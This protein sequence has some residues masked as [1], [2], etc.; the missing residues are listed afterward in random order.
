MNFPASKDFP[1]NGPVPVQSS[2][3]IAIAKA[4][5]ETIKV[6]EFRQILIWPLALDMSTTPHTSLL[7]D[8]VKEE[9][10]RLDK[11]LGKPWTR[12]VDPLFHIQ[13]EA[14]ELKRAADHPPLTPRERQEAYAEF[15]YFHDFVQRFLYPTAKDQPAGDVPLYVFK[16]DDIGFVQASIFTG[17]NV[18]PFT[19]KIERC[20]LYMFPVGV[21]V[22]AFEV[23]TSDA[24][25]APLN[26][27]QVMYLQDTLRR[28]YTPYFEWLD[29]SGSYAARGTVSSM[30]WLDANRRPIGQPKSPRPFKTEIDHVVAN[31]EPP[32]FE[33]WRDLLSLQVKGQGPALQSSQAT[34]RHVVD[35]RIPFT[36]YIRLAAIGDGADALTAYQNLSR[37]YEGD[38]MRLCFADTPGDAGS[39]PYDQDFLKEFETDNCYNRFRN[40]GTRHMFCGYTYC[41][42]TAEGKGYEPF[43][44]HHFRHMYFQMALIAHMEMAAYLAFSSRVSQAVQRASGAN[45]LMEPEFRERIIAIQGEFL[46]FVQM[47]RFTGI[48]NQIQAKEMFD[49]WRQHLRLQTLYEDVRDELSAATNFLFAVEARQQTK[50]AL[51]Q[52][53]SALQLSEAATRLNK[54][55][56][57]GVVLSLVF[58]FL[59]INVIWDGE[60][61]KVL[62]GQAEI[63]ADGKPRSW[64]LAASIG[65][66]AAIFG[67]SL[68]AFTSLALVFVPGLFEG[69]VKRKLTFYMRV[70]RCLG[71]NHA[72]PDF[73]VLEIERFLRWMF[74]VGLSVAAVGVL[75]GWSGR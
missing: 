57:A 29:A 32:I 16:R 53:E 33:P 59:G 1:M 20:N 63:A 31:R 25:I 24:T 60:T 7:A 8:I 69:K 27:T 50:S 15:V 43:L 28:C 11:S 56:I 65:R 70:R 34:W 66:G 45:R 72:E 30:Q 41:M 37:V 35:E 10:V 9:A 51:Q 44:V 14:D 47:Y 23:S 13:R 61:M 42:L 67:T 18:E 21:A 19:L 12:I 2:A 68:L 40:L 64:S 74:V 54:I 58:G 38:L 5:P 62:L 46:S 17:R 49:L 22:L 36:S 4:A 6:A 48:S 52:T 55:A 71:L 73:A 26:L 39:Y 75:I 3:S